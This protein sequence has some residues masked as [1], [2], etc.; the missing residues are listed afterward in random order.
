[1][2]NDYI[3]ALLS[4]LT[5]N[6]AVNLAHSV[7]DPCPLNPDNIHG[8]GRIYTGMGKWTTLAAIG[9]EN[10]AISLG[11]AE[12]RGQFAFAYITPLGRE[13]AAYLAAHWDEV[14]HLLRDTDQERLD[15]DRRRFAKRAQSA[16]TRH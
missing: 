12:R 11:L 14:E 9:V 15:R 10:N 5:Y 7:A 13:V 1:M 6:A 8:K 16:I 4:R 2:S 3:A